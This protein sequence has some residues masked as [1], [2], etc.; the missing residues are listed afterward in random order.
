MIFQILNR[1]S[2]EQC[3]VCG[4]NVILQFIFFIFACA[5]FNQG[6]V[7]RHSHTAV[8]M[9]NINTPETLQRKESVLV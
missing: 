7:L 2:L 9:A 4:L 8:L 6:G 3:L 1:S 5:T